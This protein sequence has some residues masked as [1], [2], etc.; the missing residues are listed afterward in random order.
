MCH[1]LSVSIIL[2]LAIAAL[3]IALVL[4]LLVLTKKRVKADAYKDN[5]KVKKSNARLL[6]TVAGISL[7][8]MFLTKIRMESV[9]AI[10][11][12]CFLFLALGFCCGTINLLNVYYINKYNLEKYKHIEEA[13]K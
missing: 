3:P 6:G 11:I 12:I 8:K 13:D 10:M 5:K 2:Q 9:I 4:M 7:G 1:V